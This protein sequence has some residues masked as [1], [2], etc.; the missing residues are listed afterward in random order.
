MRIGAAD[1]AILALYVVGTVALGYWIGRGTRSA[2]QYTVGGRE[3][4]WLLILLSIIAT[5][6]STVTFLSIPGFAYGRD[7]SWLQIAFGFLLGRLLVAALLLPQYFR[8]SLVSAYE[9]LRGRF[10]G[11]VGQTASVLFVA[12]RTVAD[13]LRLYLT[14]IVVQEMTGWPLAVAV[15]VAGVATI[16]YTWFGG[17]RAVLW[18]DAAQFALY[19]LGAFVALSIRLA[20]G[21]GGLEGVLAQAGEAGKLRLFDLS[22]DLSEPYTLLAGVLGGIFVT[23]GSHGVDQMM[24]QRYL[25]ARN[26]GDA[27]RA[28][29]TSGFVVVAQFALFLLLGLA[30]WSF[31]GGAGATETFA[32]TDRVF[33][34]FILDEMPAGLVGLLLGAIFA[35][36]LSG[37][38]NSCATTAARDLWR[39]RAGAS[40]TDQREL[41]VTKLLT[42]VF[43]VAQIVV[44]IAGQ[45]LTSSVVEAVLGIA[46]FTAGLVLGVFFLGM[47]VE[48]AGSRAALAG[49]VVGLALMTAVYFGTDLAWPWYPLVGSAVTFTVGWAVSRVVPRESDLQPAR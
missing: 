13:G 46:G 38:L 3:Q 17:L 12:T 15:A 42:A 23:L 44:A 18:A 21:P 45:W 35:A 34:R 27:R 11:A 32:Q 16:L 25:S 37:S 40:A 9:V 24:V 41:A 49:L 48:G 1:L 47:F 31:Y 10:G 28:L 4:P 33:V 30:L 26:L 36:G 43:G 22:F 14:A 29:I 2:E 5:E 39:P 20:R 19:I 7:I 8:G 6:T